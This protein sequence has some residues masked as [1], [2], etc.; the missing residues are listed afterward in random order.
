MGLE[1][2]QGRGFGEGGAEMAE[3]LGFGGLWWCGV[4]WV[5]GF[6]FYKPL[7][8]DGLGI[9]VLSMRHSQLL[10]LVWLLQASM[11][12]Y[13]QPCNS[14]HYPY[15]QVLGIFLLFPGQ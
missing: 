1:W 13:H 7:H 11:C 6:I 15:G 5:V 8:L 3:Y 4:E 12:L 14:H 2:K 9:Q 10:I